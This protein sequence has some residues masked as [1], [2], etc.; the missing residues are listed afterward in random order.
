MTSEWTYIGLQ[1]LVSTREDIEF[2]ETQIQS[3]VYNDQ[4]VFHLEYE[5][6]ADPT[7]TTMIRPFIS[8]LSVDS[9]DK[10]FIGLRF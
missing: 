10:K 4:D 8:G 2:G 3:P 7:S 1:Y 6:K 9:T 5:L